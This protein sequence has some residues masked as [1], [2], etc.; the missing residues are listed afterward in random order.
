M[1]GLKKTQVVT[2]VKNEI[3]IPIFH[4]DDA[5]A[6]S[7]EAQRQGKTAAF[8]FCLDTGMS[9]IG[10]QA[11]SES[12]EICAEIAKLPNIKAEGIFSHFATADESELSKALAEKTE[13]VSSYQMQQGKI[14]EGIINALKKLDG[15][16]NAV[17]ESALRPSETKPAVQEAIAPAAAVSVP[18]PQPQIQTEQNVEE[19]LEEET[20]NTPE[21]DITLPVPEEDSDYPDTQVNGDFDIF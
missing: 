7:A 21:S 13:L 11:D 2:V 1:S 16:E 15:V 19:D 8:H 20:F 4:P 17:L 5:K 3:R 12:A 14:E 6:L 18:E 10:F 9:R